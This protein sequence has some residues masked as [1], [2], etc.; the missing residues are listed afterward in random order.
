MPLIKRVAE[1]QGESRLCLRRFDYD[2]ENKI[3]RMV[4]APLPIIALLI[5]IERP[6][7]AIWL[8]TAVPVGVIDD[9]FV[10]IPAMIVVMVVVV[11]ADFSTPNAGHGNQSGGRKSQQRGAVLERSHTMILLVSFLSR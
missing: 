11:V 4:V 8:V 7:F 3:S 5:L 2:R 9:H 6:V 1:A 10:V